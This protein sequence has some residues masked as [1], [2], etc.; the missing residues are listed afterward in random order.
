MSQIPPSRK[1]K[2][3][4]KKTLHYEESAR[5]EQAGEPRTLHSLHDDENKHGEDYIIVSV[6]KRG[7]GQHEKSDMK[8]F[9][10]S[11]L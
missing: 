4:K 2:K 7:T 5:P 1:I 6:T 11:P 10:L 8:S 9:F 3:K